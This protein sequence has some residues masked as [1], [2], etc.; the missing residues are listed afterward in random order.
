M[1]NTFYRVFQFFSNA[2]EGTQIRRS[3]AKRVK[4]ELEVQLYSFLTSTLDG[5][6]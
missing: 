5:G 4:G 6:D 1:F 2:T 3:Q